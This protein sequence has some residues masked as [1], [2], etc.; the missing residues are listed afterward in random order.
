MASL[1]SASCRSTISFDCSGETRAASIQFYLER[2]AAALLR[3][4]T[5]GVTNKDLAHCSGGYGEEVGA[6]LPTWVGLVGQTQISLVDQ[7]RS[8][9]CV[10]GTLSA[11]MT[12]GEASE[13]LID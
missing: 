12:M 1:S 9:Q 8:L 2:A 4:L 5:S 6:I 13:F 3:S 7:R 10:V 11:H